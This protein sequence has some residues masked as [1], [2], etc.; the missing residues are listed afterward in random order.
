M[1][2]VPSESFLGNLTCAR[3]GKD[4]IDYRLLAGADS[5]EAE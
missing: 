5:K 1:V 3:A 4:S 2:I